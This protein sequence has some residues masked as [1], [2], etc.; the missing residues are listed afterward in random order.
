MSSTEFALVVLASLILFLTFAL[1][2]AAIL[3]GNKTAGKRITTLWLSGVTKL[4]AV[5]ARLVDISRSI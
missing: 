2:V 3:L 5:I 1:T 4:A